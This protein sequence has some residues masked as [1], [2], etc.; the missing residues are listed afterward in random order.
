MKE[1]RFW[2]F[3]FSSARAQAKHISEIEAKLASTKEKKRAHLQRLLA[4]ADPEGFL[5]QITEQALERL[6]ARILA[7]FS[8][9][10][11]FRCA[12]NIPETQ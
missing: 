11:G 5:K 3:Y 10:T 9:A 6:N 8:P 12:Q 2:P 1:W 7:D 4:Y